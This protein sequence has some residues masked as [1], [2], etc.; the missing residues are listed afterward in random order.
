MKGEQ[1]Q[2]IGQDALIWL[3]AQPEALE[4]FLDASGASPDSLRSQAADPEF[5]AALIDFLLA[6]DETVIAF[7][8]ACGL[9]PD[10]LATD[11]AR[12]RAA[13]VGETPSWT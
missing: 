9:R 6:A 5:L 3:A 10:A 1:A 7:A 12:A 8:G 11:L 13:L 4:A 2:A